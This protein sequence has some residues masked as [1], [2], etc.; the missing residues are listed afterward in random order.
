MNEKN[1]IPMA[2]TT[3]NALFGPV[4]LIAA[5][6]NPARRFRTQIE[7]KKKTKKTSKTWTKKTTYL[8][9]KRHKTRRLGPFF[10]SLPNQILPVVLEHE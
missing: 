10:S 3:Q 8:W 1:H 5:Q 9:P 2:Q 6:P 7:P 4:F